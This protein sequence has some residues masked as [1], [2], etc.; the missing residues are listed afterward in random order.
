MSQLCSCVISKCAKCDI[1]PTHYLQSHC[2]AVEASRL[3][4]KNFWPVVFHYPLSSPGKI[5]VTK[6]KKD[7]T[8]SHLCREYRGWSSIQVKNIWAFCHKNILLSPLRSGPDSGKVL[9]GEKVDLE[10]ATKSE[11]AASEKV[12][13]SE[14]LWLGT[15]IV[16]C[17][18]LWWTLPNWMSINHPITQQLFLRWWWHW[19]P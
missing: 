17:A 7:P 8:H 12:E 6:T 10:H 18:E 2:P 1:I 19:H 11:L 15:I 14:K 13:A 3:L 5:F 16:L 4:Q 9:T